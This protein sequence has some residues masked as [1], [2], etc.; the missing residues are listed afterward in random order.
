[1][2]I[3]PLVVALAASSVLCLRASAETFRVPFPYPTI[4]SAINVSYDGD[5]I[6]VG[7]GTYRE[8][9]NFGGRNVTVRSV[10]GPAATTIDPDS[11]RCFTA[12][13]QKGNGARLE[14]FTLT[15]GSADRG[16][17]VLVSGSSPTFVDCVITANAASGGGGGVCV[18]SGAPRFE[19]CTINGNVAS[20]SGG[21]ILVQGGS[22][23]LADSAVIENVVTSNGGNGGPSGGGGIFALP[24]ANVRITGGQVRGNSTL[25]SGGG[26]QGGTLAVTNCLIEDNQA[27]L[28][29]GIHGATG[30]I[31][32]GT[33]SGNTAAKGGGIWTS[34]ALSVSNLAIE[35]NAAS[36][37]AAMFVGG[38]ACEVRGCSVKRNAAAI[39]G[40]ILVATGSVGIG[41]T[42]LCDNQVNVRGT[43]QDLGGN[44]LTSNCAGGSA[45]TRTVPS[46][47]YPTIAAAVAASADGDLV[48][49]QPGTYRESIDLSAREITV[50]SVGGPV[51]TTID[52]DSGRCF[53]A[54]GQKGNGARIE[55]FTLTG[56]AADR[57][58]G[59]FVAASSPSIVDCVVTGNAASGGGGGVFVESGSPRFER[60]R[61][62]GNVGTWWGGG[63]YVQGGS[64]EL[65]DSGILD[66]VITS[67]GGYVPPSGGGGGGLFVAST[68]VRVTLT[69]CDVLRNAT[70]SRGGGVLGGNLTITDCRIAENDA[71]TGGGIADAIVAV[72]GGSIFDNLASRGGGLDGVSGSIVGC[73]LRQNAAS[74]SGGGLFSSGTLT[75]TD[76]IIAGNTAAGEGGGAV[77]AGAITFVRTTFTANRAGRGG[78]LHSSG[79]AVLLSCILEANEATSG[80]GGGLSGSA[81]VDG[82]HLERNRAANGFGGAWNA[83]GAST[84]RDSSVSNNEALVV[85]GVR[86]EGGVLQ[87]SGCS[88]CGN[89]VNIG[90]AWS[91]LGGNSLL[92]QCAPQCPGDASGD[93][94]IDGEDLGLTISRW[95]PCEGSGCYSD[96][97]H[98]GRVNGLDL[99]VV[100]SNWGRCPTP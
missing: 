56:G 92:G 46:P 16:G 9:V 10:E 70:A 80:N 87:V 41:T 2:Q 82:C 77:A 5:V 48:L 1:M 22:V 99:G 19:R 76:S 21:G 79:S 11:G 42:V 64:P 18:E 3:R 89:G 68:G 45:A 88:F 90:G 95:G 69:R 57:G 84:L 60:C 26:I 37:G 38:G 55:G 85:G 39:V 52:P 72:S 63:M 74:A 49:V 53:T 7:A 67:G 34:S 14:G 94:V 96:F 43:W 71:S 6:L 36:E 83:I 61:I 12:I 25:S 86:L 20:A 65:V 51:A 58:G 81:T 24:S 8:S 66:N 4:A 33:I 15:G 93:G 91:D 78:G 98:D 27:T 35:E 97:D 47:E 13:G 31:S 59:I 62:T 30:S 44:S 40:G 32:G 29:G 54:V 23:E 75:V 28:G 100:L 73:E 50:R 17:G